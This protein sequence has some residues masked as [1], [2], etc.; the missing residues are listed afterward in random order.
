MLEEL[1]EKQLLLPLIAVGALAL[2]LACFRLGWAIKSFGARRREAALHKEVRD[3][4]TSVPLLESN[5]RSREQLVARLQDELQSQKERSVQLQ[6]EHAERERQLKNALTEVRHLTHELRAIK[7]K[8]VDSSDID[9][10]TLAEAADAASGVLSPLAGKLRV[11]EQLYDKLKM[12][13]IERSERIEVLEQL[14]KEA[15]SGNSSGDPSMLSG[16]EIDA[17]QRQLDQR[18][19]SI[20]ELNAQVAQLKQEK[21]MV[22]ALAQKRSK[23]NRSLKDSKSDVEARKLELEQAVEAHQKTISDRE[24]SIHRL[25]SE[26]Q[27]VRKNLRDSVEEAHRLKRANQ[28]RDEALAEAMETEQSLEQTIARHEAKLRLAQDELERAHASVARLRQAL[29]D[30]MQLSQAQP[31]TPEDSPLRSA[32]PADHSAALQAAVDVR[33][34][35]FNDLATTLEA[36][37]RAHEASESNSQPAP[38]QTD[39]FAPTNGLN[40]RQIGGVR[41]DS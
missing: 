15:E 41:S 26:V 37:H 16:Q 18:N 27:V 31:V 23:S 32:N 30:V 17:L 33:L 8:S 36:Q 9:L 20:V 34:P 21:D 40:P 1:I 2:S 39:Q 13:L 28:A 38:V 6:S 10:E 19:R 3:A 35:V 29:A 4:R 12:A 14:V 22:E 24:L 25:L 7:G 11:T 5:I